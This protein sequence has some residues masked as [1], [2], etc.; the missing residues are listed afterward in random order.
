ME[1]CTRWNSY[2][3]TRRMDLGF[4]CSYLCSNM[5]VMWFLL[6]VILKTKLLLLSSPLLSFSLR[7]TAYVAKVFAMASHL[8]VVPK[9]VIC[10]AIKFLILNAQRPDGMFIEVGKVFSSGM[11]VR[12]LIST[13]ILQLD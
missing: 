12:T 6:A 13:S 3:N 9:H 7:L 2:E 4:F 8:V 11:N 5:T 10:D 1:G